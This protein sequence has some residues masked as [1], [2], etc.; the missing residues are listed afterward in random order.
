LVRYLLKEKKRGKTLD[1]VANFHLQ[2]GAVCFIFLAFYCCLL[3]ENSLIFKDFLLRRDQLTM[4]YFDNLD[5]GSLKKYKKI[6][7][8]EKSL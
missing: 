2:N 5:N 6:L 1:A 7:K 3:V 8:I 4:G